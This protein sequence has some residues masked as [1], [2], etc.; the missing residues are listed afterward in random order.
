MMRNGWK[1]W[2][3]AF[4]LLFGLGLWINADDIEA[5]KE[6]PPLVFTFALPLSVPIGALII[7]LVFSAGA[8]AFRRMKEDAEVP[9]YRL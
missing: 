7:L 5:A 1:L 2:P 3:L 4:I 9:S 8:R 6:L